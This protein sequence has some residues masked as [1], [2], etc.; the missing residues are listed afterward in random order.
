MYVAKHVITGICIFV[1]GV[2]IAMQMVRLIANW[3]VRVFII[4]FVSIPMH[5]LLSSVTLIY[6]DCDHDQLH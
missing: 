1:F 4:S 2:F 5:T 6:L 3:Y